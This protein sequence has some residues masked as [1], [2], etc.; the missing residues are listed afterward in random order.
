MIISTSFYSIRSKDH[1]ITLEHI[2]KQAFSPYSNKVYKTNAIEY[3]PYGYNPIEEEE[4]V[5]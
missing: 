5:I 3:V 1:N 2:E 4:L